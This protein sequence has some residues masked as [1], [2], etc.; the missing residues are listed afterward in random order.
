MKIRVVE[1]TFQKEYLLRLYKHLLCSHTFKN[2]L[3]DVLQST[4]ILDSK[5]I[6]IVYLM[7]LFLI[8]RLIQFENGVSLCNY[9]QQSVKFSYICL[10]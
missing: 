4:K 6:A 2:N 3:D 8:E 9:H 10:I 7:L 1:G 5:L